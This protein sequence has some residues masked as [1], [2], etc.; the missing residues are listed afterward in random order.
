MKICAIEITSK[1]FGCGGPSF[2][3][4]STGVTNG[5]RNDGLPIGAG[6]GD[7]K[8]DWIVPDI[9]FGSDLTQACANHDINYSTCGVTKQA[10]DTQL[11]LD[12]TN[13][14]GG[15]FLASAVGDVYYSGVSLGGQN[16]YDTAQSNA[17]CYAENYT[18]STSDWTNGGAANFG[19]YD[20]MEY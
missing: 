6:C 14:L 4:F 13:S 17:G 8:T 10:A 18:N 11:G 2:G 9:V 5:T 15:G 16:A 3:S 1:V 7:A 20:F 19:G 12:I